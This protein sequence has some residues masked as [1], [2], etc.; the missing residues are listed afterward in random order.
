M[1]SFPQVL[2]VI[3]VVLS[4]ASAADLESLE[5]SKVESETQIKARRLEDDQLWDVGTQVY[6]E[7][8]SE[9]G[10]SGT[11][12]SFNSTEGLYM[13]TWED[14]T[15]ELY[16]DEDT[17]DQMVSGAK[18]DT[19]IEP[20]DEGSVEG[21]Y[22]AG[23][24]FGND[25]YIVTLGEDD[26]IKEVENIPIM[27]QMAEHAS[28]EDGKQWNVGTQVYNEPP[29]EGGLSGT[30]TS[31]NSTERVYMVTWED[32]TTDYYDDADGE[33]NQMVAW[34]KGIPEN[35]P[36]D[37][38]FSHD[39]GAYPA[40]TI[41]Q[42]G[43]H[44]PIDTYNEIFM[45]DLEDGDTSGDNEFTLDP[46][47][48]QDSVH[49]PI[50]TYNEIFMNDLEDGDTSGDNEFTLDPDEENE[51]EPGEDNESVDYDNELVDKEQDGVHSP[52]D[53]YNEIFMNDSEDG[54]TP[55][56][57]ESILDPDEENEIEPG[58]D[59]ESVDYDDTLIDNGYDV[60]IEW[61]EAKDSE[62][63]EEF[64]KEFNLLDNEFDDEFEFDDDVGFMSD[65]DE[66]ESE[67]IDDDFGI[68]AD[69]DYS[70]D[71]F[72]ARDDWWQIGG[73]MVVFFGLIFVSVCLLG[74][75]AR[76][77]DD[78]DTYNFLNSTDGFTKIQNYGA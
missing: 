16:D 24:E 19:Q 18:S 47:E 3:C 29:N 6:N 71:S 57:N 20:V 69:D 32:G 35:N 67:Y 59:D 76:R 60:N 28:S 63:D 34:A 45:N 37:S 4:H 74:S 23:A 48:E 30:I 44:S 64:D 66:D 58:K 22:T 9:G 13:V 21:I 50:D 65:E 78:R 14:G 62:F 11:I 7:F 38:G 73:A 54:D 39:E 8:P 75:S 70:T 12:S 41:E 31:F 56:D 36:A 68:S 40:G 10:L 52:I 49:S 61:D 1:I 77:R 53:T 72:F 15:I 42:D 55:G 26:E 25:T 51:I 46:D 43:V 17:I 33:V 27:D 5:K 2:I